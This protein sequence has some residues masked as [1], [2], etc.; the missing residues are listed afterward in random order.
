MKTNFMI[1]KRIIGSNQKPYVIAEMSANHNGDFQKAK[2]IITSAKKNGA[3]AIKIQTYTAD[4]MTID[5][6]KS[7]FKIKHGLWKDNYLYD[8]YKSAETPFE[9]QK[10]LFDFAKDENII[11]FSSAFDEKAVDLLQ[12]IDVPAYKI[13]SF[14]ITDLP[15][16]KYIALTGKPILLSTGMSSENEIA[17]ALD[18]IKSVGNNNIL[19][20]HCIS[21]YPANLKDSNLT[22]I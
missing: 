16:V 7:D 21:S 18:V 20:F 1:N 15:L 5:T 17:M 14:E 4:T 19:L 9:W 2:E 3:N 11:L 12:K 6:K 10:A 13:A 8:L 22:M